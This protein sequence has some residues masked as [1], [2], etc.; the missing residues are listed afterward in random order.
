[1]SGVTYSGAELKAK[2]RYGLREQALMLTSK[3]AYQSRTMRHHCR[4]QQFMAHA[5]GSYTAKRWKCA[6]FN[7]GMQKMRKRPLNLWG[8]FPCT[9]L[10]RAY[11]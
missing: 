4:A 8:I 7:S 5:Q 6:A 2:T 10:Q 9:M 11:F 1:M 3:Q